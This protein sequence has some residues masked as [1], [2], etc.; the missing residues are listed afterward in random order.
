MFPLLES[1]KRGGALDQG[2]A[3]PQRPGQFELRFRGVPG[4]SHPQPIL[5]VARDLTGQRL[6]FARDPRRR[7]LAWSGRASTH[8][9]S[10][11]FSPRPSAG[12]CSFARWPGWLRV[13]AHSPFLGNLATTISGAFSSRCS[14]L[15][16][17]KRS[18]SFLRS[19]PM[20]RSAFS[21]LCCLEVRSRST[22]SISAARN[23]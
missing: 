5:W 13:A 6:D 22:D 21:R 19:L 14:A 17:R 8:C 23:R 7:P 16:W 18:P 3:D 4:Q 20:K 11:A 2:D 10:P 1:S 15:L 12:Q 9:G